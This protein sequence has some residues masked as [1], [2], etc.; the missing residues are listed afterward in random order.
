MRIGKIVKQ[1]MLRHILVPIINHPP[2]GQ[3]KS[4]DLPHPWNQRR[5]VQRLVLVL[6]R[7][8]IRLH[9][10]VVHHRHPL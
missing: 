6:D 3:T 7:L 4:K 5:V 8:V 9:R 1:K 2:V 10:P